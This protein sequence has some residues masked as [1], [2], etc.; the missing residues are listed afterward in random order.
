MNGTDTTFEAYFEGR[1]G[2]F[3]GLVIEQLE[4][5]WEQYPVLHLDLNARKY[6]TVTD[7]VDM[8][9]QYLEKWG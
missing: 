2:L 7:L 1:K 9:N 6:E 3:Q 4:K 5:K 8:L